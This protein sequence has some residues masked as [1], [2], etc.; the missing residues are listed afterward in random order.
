[1]HVGVVAEVASPGVQDA[2]HTDLAA[3]KTRVTGQLLGGFC[4]SAEE[5]VVNELRLS[6]GD[7]PE[8]VRQGEGEQEVGNGQAQVLLLL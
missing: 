8:S 7:L 6:T 2:D 5:Q 1:M 3:D 4:G